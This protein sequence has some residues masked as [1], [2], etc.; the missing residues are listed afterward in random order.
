M[1]VL[2]R[3]ASRWLMVLVA[4]SVPLH[5][6]AT[7]SKVFRLR[8][9]DSTT[10]TSTWT[11]LPTVKVE[12]EALGLGLA[13]KVQATTVIAVCELVFLTH[14]SWVRTSRSSRRR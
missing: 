11:S 9:G 6:C 14:E 4:V 10:S 1:R 8:S 13:A 5:F 3:K 7:A 12:T 2:G